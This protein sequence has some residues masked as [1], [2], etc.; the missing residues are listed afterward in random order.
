MAT[1]VTVDERFNGYWMPEPNSG[2]WMWFGPSKQG[3]YGRMH[4]NGRKLLAHRYS[5]ERTNG[6]I[7]DGLM[8]SNIVRRTNWSHVSNV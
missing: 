7:V 5:W 1:A 8:V 6:P 2:C 3:G 4:I